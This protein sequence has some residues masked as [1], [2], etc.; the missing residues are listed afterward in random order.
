VLADD[1]ALDVGE[2]LVA[3][4]LDLGRHEPPLAAALPGRHAGITTL[5]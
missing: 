5:C 2:D 3:G 4:L 1:H